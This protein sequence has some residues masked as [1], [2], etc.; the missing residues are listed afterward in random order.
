MPES[1]S[2][3]PI[4]TMMQAVIST[5]MPELPA[6][7]R[8]HIRRRY[9]HWT[10]IW[11]AVNAAV[12]EHM[13]LQ[14]IQIPNLTLLPTMEHLRFANLDKLWIH[15]GQLGSRWPHLLMKNFQM[16]IESNYISHISV[17]SDLVSDLPDDIIT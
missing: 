15:A 9:P 5:L 8:C 4:F 16:N 17:T 13:T 3:N 12:G 10:S 11:A 14:R 7:V 6:Q 1:P 2:P